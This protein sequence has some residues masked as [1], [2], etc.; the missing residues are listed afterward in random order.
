MPMEK[1]LENMNLNTVEKKTGSVKIKKFLVDYRRQTR[2]NFVLKSITVITFLPFA[3]GFGEFIYKKYTSGKADSFF[4]KT[5]PAFTLLKPKLNYET[6]EYIAKSNFLNK[7]KKNLEEVLFGPTSQRTFLFGQPNFIAKIKNSKDF[8]FNKL[9][10]LSY[11]F[12][13]TQIS[14]YSKDT[15]Y[16][17]LD[18]LP[19][20][21]EAL[22]EKQENQSMILDQEFDR[23]SKKGEA[24]SSYELSKE[25][26][27]VD[28]L[29]KKKESQNRFFLKPTRSQKKLSL[30]NSSNQKLSDVSH[31]TLNKIS[32]KN[33]FY[34]NRLDFYVN[35]KDLNSKLQTLFIEK[36]VYSLP[37]DIV[38]NN[39]QSAKLK[40]N[41]SIDLESKQGGRKNEILRKVS[42]PSKMENKTD[43]N[44]KREDRNVLKSLLENFSEVDYPI[45]MDEILKDFNK[46][47]ISDEF[48]G[49]RMMSG[50]D[51][52]D[53]TVSD[54]YWFYVKNSLLGK[55]RSE[56]FNLEKSY[57]APFSKKYTFNIPNLP[58][59]LV[60]TKRLIFKNSETNK[61]LYEGP[62]L[63]LDSQKAF[64]WKHQAY[65]NE[66][67]F[68]SPKKLQEENLRFWFH[69]YLSPYNSLVHLQ[70]NFFGI[71]HS[72]EYLINGKTPE[73]SEFE[74]NA[75]FNLHKFT[76][77]EEK[78]WDLVRP[79]LKTNFAPFQ[80]SIHIPYESN[81]KTTGKIPGLSENTTNLFIRGVNLKLSENEN[82]NHTET[83]LPVVQLQQPQFNFLT[84][85]SKIFN[86]SSPLFENG[87]IAKLDYSIPRDYLDEKNFV[88]KY[89]SGRYKKISSIFS[90][91]KK[92]NRIL[93]DN[94]EP[95]TARSWLVISQLSFAVFSFQILKALADNYGRELLAYLLDLVA[96]L[97]FL[98]DS[99]KQEIE[100]L[101]GQ[102]EKGF[103]IISKSRKTFTDIAGIRQLLPEIYELVWFLRNSA[104]EFAQS[105]T[106]PRGVLLTGPPGTGKT[107]LVQ[108]LAGEAQVPVVVLSGSSLI[109]PGE[110]GASKLEMV[111]QEARQVAPCIVFIDEIDTLAQKRRGVAHNVMDPDDIVESINSSETSTTSSPRELMSQFQEIQKLDKSIETSIQGDLKLEQLSLL[112]QLLIELDG[113]QARD[114]VIVIGATNRPEVL[115]PAILRPGRFDKI[116][117]VGLPRQQKRIEILKL[118][119][120]ALGYKSEI[121]WDY[122]AQRTEGFSAA[123]LATLMNESSIKAI[124]N[125]TAHTVET[126]EHGI[127]RLTTS[128]NE[129]SLVLRRQSPSF[130]N[131]VSEQDKTLLFSSKTSLLRLAY[132]QAGKVVVSQILETHP[133]VVVAYLWP[134]RTTI[135]SLQITTNLQNSI[136]QFA[137]LIELNERIIAS[138]AGKA[139]EFLFLQKFAKTTSSNVS[140]IQFSNASTLGL[141]DLLF[142]QKLIYSLIE[143]WSFYTKKFQIQKTISLASN[144]NSREFN[145][146]KEKI[147]FYNDFIERIETPPM[148]EAVQKETSSLFASKEKEVPNYNDQMYYSIPWWQQEV[149]YALEFGE[150]NF[151]N[152][153]RLYLYS[154]V[155]SERNPEWFPPDEFYHS[156]SGLKNVKKAFA[157]LK[158]FYKLSARKDLKN[159]QNKTSKSIEKSKKV[160]LK[161]N[162]VAKLTRDYPFHSLVLQSFN[163]SL[164]L[165]NQ[166]REILDQIVIEL[167][168]HEILRQPELEI[169]FKD[170]KNLN[171]TLDSTN[172]SSDSHCLDN[173]K[174]QNELTV[175][176]VEKQKHFQIVESNW[177]L[178][179]RKKFPRW[180]DF[181]DLN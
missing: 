66:T 30:L 160:D 13:I 108:A 27:K 105:K 169:L 127:D 14:P 118:Y 172:V 136:F 174:N 109:E 166:N 121:T 50:Y 170:F 141:E 45:L 28:F 120:Q 96:A 36:N 11:Q 134:R 171:K 5:L 77:N 64:D 177:G 2:Q 83:F 142:A 63:I 16:K 47:T 68:A 162:D 178:A 112:T 95:L 44:L 53:M 60:E 87:L 82:S 72:P 71:D 56:N 58:A 89:V 6:F 131:K 37:I 97:G 86:S 62:A 116:L 173:L 19:S 98:D 67:N 55:L 149:S 78:R 81:N 122:L 115:D 138:Y 18:E 102:R 52:P 140:K 49:F 7:E 164:L 26:R 145:Q 167:L 146:N 35:L 154:P 107:L 38:E 91:T 31:F 33:Q 10:G 92:S 137:R 59:V 158:A 65:P 75:F 161:W 110:S 3:L 22:F 126:I 147:E 101:M 159:S 42:S 180:I 123:D 29:E 153:S 150:K 1:D 124:L 114:G 90:R 94:W 111:F 103:R 73:F 23:F 74:Q 157:N 151:A 88:T 168:Y 119:G 57:L 165:L 17:N 69:K 15:F 4:Q 128:Q 144:I 79:P 176:D 21:L 156:Y 179:S 84:T 99:L 39:S 152:W 70:E 34:K 181:H 100:V 148:S 130:P 46:K 129:K 80:F 41:L 125:Q 93:I 20:Y 61:I 43:V 135:R 54:L 40:K 133:N 48:T 25:T 132:Y 9:N 24:Q 104:R 163:K 51:Y 32:P 143:K 175:I 76:I 113:I 8:S 117:Q 85:S 155:K 12:Y 106:L 139:A